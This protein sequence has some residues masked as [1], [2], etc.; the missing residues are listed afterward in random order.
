MSLADVK[1]TI[2][3]AEAHVKNIISALYHQNVQNIDFVVRFVR[4]NHFIWI[5]QIF[6]LTHPYKKRG[7]SIPLILIAQ[8]P[9]ANRPLRLPPSDA[10]PEMSRVVWGNQ[11]E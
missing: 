1:K 6:L 9:P 4:F 8:T 10:T 11:K 5:T 7:T 2:Y 3:N